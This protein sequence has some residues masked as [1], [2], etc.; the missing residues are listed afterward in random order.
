MSVPWESV[1]IGVHCRPYY[2]GPVQT[3]LSTAPLYFCE[4]AQNPNSCKNI[5]RSTRLYYIY[6]SIFRF[7]SCFSWGFSSEYTTSCIS[8]SPSLNLIACML[9]GGIISDCGVG[10]GPTI[11]LVSAFFLDNAPSFDLN[12]KKYNH[13][14]NNKCWAK[15][16]KEAKTV[17]RVYIWKD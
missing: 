14:K 17:F 7:T 16:P 3:K 15:Y 13:L 11:C 12:F 10:A 5:Y 8:C 6:C 4:L 2:Q 1:I 9:P